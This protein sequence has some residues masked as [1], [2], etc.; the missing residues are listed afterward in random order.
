MRALTDRREAGRRL[1]AEL[2][3]YKGRP[4]TIVLGLP[5]GGVVVAYEVAEALQVPL[6][7]YLVRKLGAPGQ[8]ELAVGAIASG[9]VRVLNEDVVFALQLSQQQ[10]DAIAAREEALLNRREQAYRGHS[11][12]VELEGKNVILVD[13]G[14][15]TG[16]SMRTAIRSLQSHQPARVVVA[17][18]VAPEETCAVL[19]REV[20]EVICLVTPAPFYSIGSWYVDFSQTTDDEVIELLEKAR[21]FGKTPP[22][23]EQKGT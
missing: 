12:K 6:D 13:D 1:A 15:A 17:V 18:P 4:D 21:L 22:P 10:I 19:R 3:E 9:G 11:R 23:A 2:E 14:L 5:R 8:E 20:D 7:V 16:A